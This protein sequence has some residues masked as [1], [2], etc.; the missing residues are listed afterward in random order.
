[1]QFRFP[2]K[3]LLAVT[4]LSYV[5]VDYPPLKISY[6]RD[7]H[8][9]KK[10]EFYPLSSFP[11]YATFSDNPYHVYVTTAAGEPVALTTTLRAHASVLKKTYEQELKKQKKLE[12]DGAS[13]LDRAQMKRIAGELT[14]KLL[15]EQQTTMDWLKTQP[16]QKLRLHEVVLTSGDDGIVREDTMVAE[17]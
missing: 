14:L 3:T 2:F 6:V 16:D 13:D 1:M 12:R 5:L 17:L 15:K 4:L 8:D 11:M 7:G 9:L 10:A